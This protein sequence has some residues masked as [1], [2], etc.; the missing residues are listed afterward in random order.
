M[1][2]GKSRV[3]FNGPAVTRQRLLP[4]PKPTELIALIPME[5]RGSG[6]DVGGPGN[7]ERAE[8]WTARGASA[9]LNRSPSALLESDSDN[10]ISGPIKE[11]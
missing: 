6:I 4:A 10:R 11:A 7:Q 2:L 9:P 1:R 5:K 3:V 8:E